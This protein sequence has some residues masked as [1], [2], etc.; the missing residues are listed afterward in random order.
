MAAELT[1]EKFIEVM[2]TSK[3]NF[4]HE[5]SSK[6][7]VEMIK[8]KDPRKITKR[9]P[10]EDILKQ[11][12]ANMS[13]VDI[14]K[15][16]ISIYPSGFNAADITNIC[17]INVRTK[18]PSFKKKEI[19]EDKFL[20][21]TTL[22]DIQGHNNAKGEIF[23]IAVELKGGDIY[24][25][26][27]SFRYNPKIIENN[28]NNN[29]NNNNKRKSKESESEEEIMPSKSRNYFEKRQLKVKLYNNNSCK[30]K[31]EKMVTS[32]GSIKYKLPLPGSDKIMNIVVKDNADLFVAAEGIDHNIILK[33]G[34]CISADSYNINIEYGK[35][36]NHVLQ[37]K[38]TGENQYFL[39]EKQVDFNAG[40]LLAPGESVDN[41]NIGRFD[42]D[43]ENMK[44]SRNILLLNKKDNTVTNLKEKDIIISSIKN[45][46]MKDGRMTIL[47]DK[48]S[49]KKIE[50]YFKKIREIDTDTSAPEDTDDE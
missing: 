24:V 33:K 28:N 26:N 38:N 27:K 25:S 15:V 1:F 49:N 36:N 16:Y 14:P 47:L 12:P 7:K 29:E 8:I 20:T 4:E 45:M 19:I 11:L 50:L 32:A 44:I 30:Y 37:F 41:Y 22:I 3:I 35:E 23:V 43:P 40:R 2:I 48:E 13:V 31:D 5:Y 18:F 21:I 39:N 17:I 10:Q 34:E 6:K 9:Y 46:K 42:I